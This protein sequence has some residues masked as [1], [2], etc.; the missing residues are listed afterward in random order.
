MKNDADHR[1]LLA[2]DLRSCSWQQI[3]TRGAAT[4]GVSDPLDM[5]TR[6]VMHPL[7]LSSKVYWVLWGC[8]VMWLFWVANTTEYVLLDTS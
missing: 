4:S 5:M 3:E 2:V 7:G 1:P 6:G 8:E